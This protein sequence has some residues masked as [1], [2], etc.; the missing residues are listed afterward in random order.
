MTNTVMEATA[1]SSGKKHYFIK[2]TGQALSMAGRK[3][4]GAVNIRSV[5]RSSLYGTLFS[6]GLALNPDKIVL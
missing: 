2:W 3:R 4:A 5:Q 6:K 1:L